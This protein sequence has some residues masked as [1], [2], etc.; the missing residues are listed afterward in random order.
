MLKNKRLAI[1]TPYKFKDLPRLNAKPESGSREGG[2]GI[3]IAIGYGSP[4]R[5]SS[6]HQ[7]AVPARIE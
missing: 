6:S 1:S 3:Y 5:R 4:E 7:P 2:E